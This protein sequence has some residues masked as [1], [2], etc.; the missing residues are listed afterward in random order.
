MIHPIPSKMPVDRAALPDLTMRLKRV[1]ETS[2]SQ[3]DRGS[4]LI[5]RWKTEADRPW[6]PTEVL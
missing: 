6:H 5:D 3:S 4:A 2:R 1:H